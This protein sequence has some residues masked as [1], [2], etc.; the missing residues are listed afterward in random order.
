MLDSFFFYAKS[1][2][3]FISFCPFISRIFRLN[4]KHDLTQ[5]KDVIISC[6]CNFNVHSWWLFFLVIDF[7]LLFS[8]LDANVNLKLCDTPTR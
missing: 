5:M 1:I 8:D 7:A 4:V 2:L 3:K 6:W